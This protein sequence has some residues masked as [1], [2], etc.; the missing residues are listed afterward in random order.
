MSSISAD[1]NMTELANT[2]QNAELKEVIFR[3][4]NDVTKIAS[5]NGYD[6][7]FLSAGFIAVFIVIVGLI[8]LPIRK[9]SINV[10]SE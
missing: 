2:I 6:G 1:T 4:V 8:L 5:E 10:K 9:K 3:S 7:L